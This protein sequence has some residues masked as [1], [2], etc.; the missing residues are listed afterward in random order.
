MAPK[1]TRTRDRAHVRRPIETRD[2]ARAPIETRASRGPTRGCRPTATHDGARRVARARGEASAREIGESRV[3]A[4][5]PRRRRAME[6][7]VSEDESTRRARRLEANRAASAASRERKRALERDAR[8]RIHELERLTHALATENAVLKDALLELTCGRRAGGV[9]KAAPPRASDGG[10]DGAWTPTPTVPMVPVGAMG[11]AWGTWGGVGG[12]A[13]PRSSSGADY[14]QSRSRTKR[15]ELARVARA[16]EDA[17][18]R[19]RDLSRRRVGEGPFG[20]TRGDEPRAGE[21]SATDMQTA[22]D[23]DERIRR[24]QTQTTSR[25]RSGAWTTTT[26]TAARKQNRR[27]IHKVKTTSMGLTSTTPRGSTTRA[28]TPSPTRARRRT[29]KRSSSASRRS[30][31]LPNPALIKQ[32]FSS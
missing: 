6:A 14:T 29:F 8:R 15:S 7:R 24:A 26:S 31:R 27:L 20:A 22:N 11:G 19:R 16:I 25:A 32:F 10:G 13:S 17:K 21:K 23:D 1:R 18:R 30:Y 12:E 9:A 2:F 28:S 5:A 3:D 4:R